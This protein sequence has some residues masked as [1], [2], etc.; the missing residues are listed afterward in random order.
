MKKEILVFVLF[1]LLI[2]GST[3]CAVKT[4]SVTKDRVDQELTG[5]RGYL[6]GS[7][8]ELEPKQ[9]KSTR[10]TQVIEIEFLTPS[11]IKKKYIEK[12]LTPSRKVGKD[13]ELKGNLGYVKGALPK[14]IEIE[15]E[16]MGIEEALPTAGVTFEKY[17]VQ[18]NDT[19]Q[20]IS[21]RF[22]GTARNWMKIYQAN[23]DILKG[24]NSIYPGQ[25][26]NIPLEPLEETEENL[27]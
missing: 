23:K 7:A 2:L 24:P 6:I 11:E 13:K 9:R 16:E 26:I 5:N 3:G 4:Y 20:K 1:V 19:L 18:K 10:T 12:S 17:T 8:A 15:K 14:G 21:Q 22:Y 25:V 27:K